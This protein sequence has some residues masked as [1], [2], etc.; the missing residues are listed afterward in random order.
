MSIS[1]SDIPGHSNLYLDFMYEFNNVSNF[2]RKDFRAFEEYEATFARVLSTQRAD[3]N[4]L[5]RIIKNQYSD[6]QPC[7]KS[8]NNID[9]LAQKDTIAVVTGQ[10][11]GLFGG[12]L[13]TFYKIVTAIKLADDLQKKHPAYNFV[14]VFWMEG[15]DHDFKEISYVE[16]PDQSG[17]LLSVKYGD[18]EKEN[19]N[20][21]SVSKL[22]I[23]EEAISEFFNK[24]DP[25]LRDND[26]K[27]KL[28]SELKEIYSSGKSFGKVFSEFIFK[29]FDKY[30]LVILNPSDGEIKK[31]LIP[32]FRKEIDNFRT[33]ADTLVETSADLEERYHTQVKLRPVNLFF[34]TA[35]G[36]F[37]IEP[38]GD[39]RLRG[40]RTVFSKDSLINELN[41][42]PE[43]FSPNVI[44]RP[45]CQDFLLPT[46]FYIGGPGEIGYFAQLIP[47]YKQF[48]IEQPYLYP[49]IS[50]TLLERNISNTLQ[51]YNLNFLDLLIPEKD[52]N[53]LAMKEIA[54]IQVDEL[55]ASVRKEI[56]QSFQSLGNELVKIDPNSADLTEKTKQRAVQGLD[57]LEDKIRKA[58]ENRHEISIRQVNRAKNAV[59]PESILQ[60]RRLNLVYFLYKYG[61]GFPERLF[62]MLEINNFQH[63][64]LEI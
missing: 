10:Q 47:L 59:F 49:R 14:P 6:F 33:H 36:R 35:D 31:L 46:G 22:L 30:G 2:Y 23:E 28:V 58:Q 40:K 4:E 63:Q 12:P 56:D 15:D 42:H 44:L 52:L 62:D 9:L 53:T 48:G 34:T 11:L 5:T 37:A 41:G 64:V 60:E 50:A 25:L 39:F 8:L 18:D 7:E 27:F 16:F 43:K 3:R 21:I 24:I 38:D 20:K 32:V 45:I 19:E 55:F 13:Y 57:I 51:K 54:T 1:F 29:F 17:S 26:F 61:P